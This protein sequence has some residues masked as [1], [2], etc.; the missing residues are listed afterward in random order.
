M[1][2]KRN[3]KLLLIT[4]RR[5]KLKKIMMHH[6]KFI[7]KSPLRFR[8]PFINIKWKYKLMSMKIL[9][10]KKQKSNLVRLKLTITKFTRKLPQLMPKLRSLR[11]NQLLFELMNLINHLMIKTILRLF[12]KIKN[13]PKFS[14]FMSRQTQSNYWPLKQRLPLILLRSK[15]NLSK[16][17]QLKVLTLSQLLTS[18]Q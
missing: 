18:I 7:K 13:R 5:L 16:L 17:N 12:S 11:K 6:H 4:R 3:R 9:L 15:I 8:N 14:Q 2:Q 10:S 1:H